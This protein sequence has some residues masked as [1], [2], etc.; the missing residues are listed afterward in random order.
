MVQFWFWKISILYK[1]RVSKLANIGFEKSCTEPKS[2]QF[3]NILGLV[4]SRI[5]KIAFLKHV[6]FTR[7]SQNLNSEHILTSPKGF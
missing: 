6:S 2:I 7:T 1:I 3:F 4:C 5:I